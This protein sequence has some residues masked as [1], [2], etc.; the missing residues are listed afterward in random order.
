MDSTFD[1]PSGA[2]FF[3]YFDLRTICYKYHYQQFI[4]D[5]ASIPTL[6][7]GLQQDWFDNKVVQIEIISDEKITKH[8]STIFF[9][10]RY[11]T[12]R[13]WFQRQLFIIEHYPAVNETSALFQQ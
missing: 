5:L 10:F 8:Q 7:F 1:S 2:I 9:Y 12:S 6:N 13:H 3:R 11:W 4:P